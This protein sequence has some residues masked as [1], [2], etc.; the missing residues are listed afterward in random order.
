MCWGVFFFF[1]LVL[2]ICCYVDLFYSRFGK[3]I[4][5][6]NIYYAFRILF[7]FHSHNLIVGYFHHFSTFSSVSFFFFFNFSL[8]DLEWQIILQWQD[9]E[10][11]NKR[12]ENKEDR[13]FGDQEVLNKL[14]TSCKQVYKKYSILYKV[15]RGKMGQSAESHHVV[16]WS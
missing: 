15:Y 6:E 1:F 7:C 14:M 10:P 8:T 13:K 3:L 16:G 5:I 11:N 4:S 2:S 12:W 9:P